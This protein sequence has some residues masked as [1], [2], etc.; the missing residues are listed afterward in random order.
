M[1]CPYKSGHKQGDL[2]A[3]PVYLN[4]DRNGDKATSSDTH[5]RVDAEVTKML[6]EAYSRV[7]ALLVR[8]AMYLS[9]LITDSLVT[10]NV[11]Q[12]SRLRI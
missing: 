10:D 5:R 3:G 1:V 8:V 12:W 9:F 6:R 11:A 4:G 7:T 2:H